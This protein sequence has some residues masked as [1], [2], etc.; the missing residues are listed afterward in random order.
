MK[1]LM[2]AGIS[3]HVALIP[4]FSE[5][6]RGKLK[7]VMTG[8]HKPAERVVGQEV[9]LLRFVFITDIK[10]QTSQQQELSMNM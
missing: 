5:D 10:A 1:V 7:D 2:M 3:T 6:L 8:S 9:T 4:A